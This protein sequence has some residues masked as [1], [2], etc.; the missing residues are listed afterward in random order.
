MLWKPL[1]LDHGFI[2]N[3]ESVSSLERKCVE[4]LTSFT[5][6]QREGK[7]ITAS[8][9]EVYSSVKACGSSDQQVLVCLAT[10]FYPK[11]VQ[12]EIRRDQTLL[13]DEQLNS[14]GIRPNTDGSFQL[15]KS[16]QI[17]PSDRS[18]YQCVVKHQTLTEP[19]IISW[20]PETHA[21]LAAALNDS[22]DDENATDDS[23]EE[24]QT[25]E[26]HE[27]QSLCEAKETPAAAPTAARAMEREDTNQNTVSQNALLLPLPRRCRSK[28]ISMPDLALERKDN[29]DLRR[30]SVGWRRGGLF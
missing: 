20:G 15:M 26:L 23:L 17:L 1:V 14:H 28:N 9:P 19:L 8:R 6:L 30:S 16:L 3:R 18:H 12:M 7:F 2:W 25:E 29:S 27:T 13:P 11:H 21:G 22:S 10:G 24:V 5:D 4:T